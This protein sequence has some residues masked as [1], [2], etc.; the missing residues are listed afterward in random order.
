MRAGSMLS[1]RAV[2]QYAGTVRHR[3][4]RMMRLPIAHTLPFG[5]GKINKLIVWTIQHVV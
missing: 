4:M 3:R 2:E 5:M 1:E